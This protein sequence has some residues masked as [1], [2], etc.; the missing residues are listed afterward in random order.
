MRET[1]RFAHAIVTPTPAN[2]DRFPLTATADALAA[3]G[4]NLG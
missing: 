3:L 1:V 2:A 4:G